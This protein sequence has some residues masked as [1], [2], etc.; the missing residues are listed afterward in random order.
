MGLVSRLLGTNLEI[1]SSSELAALLRGGRETWSGLDVS[2]SEA[3]KVSAWYAGHAN[4]AEDI[5]KMPFLLYHSGEK[6]ERATTSPY[7]RLV[8][9]RWSSRWTSQQGREFMTFW[10][11]H[12]GDAYALKSPRGASVPRELIPFPRGKVEKDEIDDGE[13]I[14]RVKLNG[15]NE[16]LTRRDVFHLEGF[17]LNHDS[18][19]NLFKMSQEDIGLS[20]ATERHG[21]TF[22]GNGAVTSLIVSHPG[23]MSDSAYDRL[24]L[25]LN[26][27]HTGANAHRAL[28]IEEG[29]KAEK[30][31]AT[32][33][34]SQ[35]LQTRQFQVTDLAR[36]LR[37]P[38]HKV[39]DNSHAT[40]SNIEHQTIE[41]HVDTLLPWALRWENAFN[42]QI[43]G[44]NAV[45]AELLLDSLMRA[46]SKT[47]A[48]FYT[49]AINNGWMTENE[50]RRRENLPPV[51]GGDDLYTQLNLA[52][53][54]DRELSQL[55][56][57]TESLGNLIGAG[58]EPEASL[59][60]VG[61]PS[62]ARREP[63][64]VS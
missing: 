54:R 34:E 40:F 1:T 7:W 13:F 62:I 47:R 52:T 49:M 33:E 35:F 38:P 17:A 18:G 23:E 55:K 22:F 24:K 46:D 59:D 21:G 9:D 25:S 32:N 36:R 42:Q 44:S 39:G 2:V 14:Y 64:V 48:E 45:Y 15:E 28:L 51:E 4:V 58:F 20:L 10:A 11:R 12:D 26:E 16:L 31:G 50:V 43:I 61:L 60:V 29:A 3:M 6:R 8:H 5:G 56:L 27:D 63:V 53:Q 41:Y 37:L 30:A 57:Q 19:A